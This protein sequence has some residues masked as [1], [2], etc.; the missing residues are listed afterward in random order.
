VKQCNDLFFIWSMLVT[1][2]LLFSLLLGGPLVPEKVERE[3]DVG[4]ESEAQEVGANKLVVVFDF[5]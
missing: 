2:S 5:D 1:S 3:A 4:V